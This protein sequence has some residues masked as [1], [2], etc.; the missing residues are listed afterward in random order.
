MELKA[1]VVGL[2]IL[3]S[4]YTTFFDEQ[5]ETQ[6][7]G[8]A[9][10]RS[11]VAREIGAPVGAEPYDDYERMFAEQTLDLAVI[12]TPD[13]LHRDPV[14]AAIEAGVPVVIQE[15]PMATTV[16]DAE[17]ML[18]AAEEAGSWIFVN[19]ANRGA[20][21]DRASYYVIREG[22][23]GDVV[24][25][26]IH[27]DDN[28]S[29][30]RQL[31]GDRSKDWAS[32]SSTAY[33]LLSHVVDLLHWIMAP[34][35]VTEVYAISQQQV[36]GYTPDLYDAFLTFDNGAKFRVKAEWIKHIDGLV[37]FALDFSGSE[38]SLRYIKYP[39]FGEVEGWRA[40]L[41]GGVT[42]E[43]LLK[44]QEA[45]AAQ[46]VEV[47]A[48]I[49]RGKAAAAAVAAAEIGPRVSLEADA[50]PKDEWRLVR[51]FVDAVLEDTLTPSSWT[52]YGPLPTGIDGLRQTRVVSAIVQSAEEDRVITLP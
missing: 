36:L 41:S 39:G 32:G 18:E 24:Y 15:K 25:G 43:A 10:I 44:H 27:L 21:L 28:I 37:E 35:E 1:G 49:Q 50:L 2:G 29:V 11:E 26:E 51:G 23:L 3:G 6:V 34:S 16:E 30:P 42:A 5:P 22:L 7:V 12:A 40:N 4:Q 8:V 31:W 14:M 20:A 52:G 48:Q 46:D 33:F 45:L 47:R 13:P 38:G 19:Y 9:D 17:A